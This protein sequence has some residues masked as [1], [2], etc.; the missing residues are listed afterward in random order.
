MRVGETVSPAKRL[1]ERKRKRYRYISVALTNEKEPRRLDNRK[2][3]PS[4]N[5]QGSTS[6]VVT[7]R[8]ATFCQIFSFAGLGIAWV[9]PIMFGYYMLHV[10]FALL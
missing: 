10:C 3:E 4:T 2:Q 8:M 1:E 5:L 9:C 7:K 6:Y